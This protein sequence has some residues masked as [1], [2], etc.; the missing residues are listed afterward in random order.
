M[1]KNIYRILFLTYFLL[2]LIICNLA[3]A[4]WSS[5][6]AIS[7]TTGKVAI[8][9]DTVEFPINVQKGYDYEEESW[10]T[11]SVVDIPQGWNAGF[12]E[13]DEQIT[14]LNF[15][16]YDDDE[17]DERE[18]ILRIKSSQS[19]TNGLYSIWVRF[20]PDEGEV[21]LREYAVKI[22]NN[23]DINLELYSDIPGLQTSPADPVDFVVTVTNDYKHRITINLDVDEKPANWSV[24]LLETEDEKY[25]IKKQ[26]IEES[27]TQNF[28]VRVNPPVNTENG[29][30]SII[31]SATPENS[32]QSVSQLLEVYIDEEL[33]K[34]EALE[35]IPQSLNL[36]LNPG[37]ETEV[38]V[39]LKNTGLQAIENVELQLQEDTGISTEI[40]TFGAIEE[41]EAG[42]S[43]KIPIEISARA[44]A[45]SGPKEILMRATSDT[46]NSEDGKI[47]VNV[48]KSESSGYIGITMIVVA[49][50][51]LGIII[52]KFGRR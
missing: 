46:I 13:D 9:G 21:I 43:V 2:T 38:S 4:D 26:S 12:Y 6:I 27:S 31:V 5:V 8:A 23:A 17:E 29:M 32:N 19:A 34:N 52:Y 41:L 22:D 18:I 50:V 1:F 44:D 20:V 3:V 30:Y 40:K 37:S 25:R 16:E 28:I 45:S 47:I 36:T 10:C 33:E 11:F 51:I 15:P 49:F 24:Q 14:S 42:E 35:I 39:T 7:P 48:E